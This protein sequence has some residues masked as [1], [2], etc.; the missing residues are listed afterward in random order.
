MPTVT[1]VA[2]PATVS[3]QI[4]VDW[5]A[6]T[7][8][9]VSRVDPDGTRVPIRGG[10]NLSLPGGVAIRYD[11]EAPL[12]VPVSYVATSPDVP[13]VEVTSA[14][15]TVASGGRAWLKHPGKPTLNRALAHFRALGA[16][17]YPVTRGV[18]AVE[19]RADPVVVSSVRRT[20]HDSTAMFRT[21]T[22]LEE[23]DVSALLADGSALLLQTPAGWR[24]GSRYVSV[25]DVDVAPFAPL[26]P[27]DPRVVWTLPLTVVARPSG[28]A[29]AGP[30]LSWG[31]LMGRYSTWGDLYDT[32]ATWQD[33][34]EGRA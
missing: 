3:V 21:G 1:A 16:G 34:A 28:L 7:T 8:A 32:G 6:A 19:G 23:A 24:W 11:Y 10:D 14:Q 15:V 29:E 33:V 13:D 5:P 27:T 17:T 22:A 26:L 31:D 20:L 2:K 12:D 18:F 25:G 9:T 30:G 4:T